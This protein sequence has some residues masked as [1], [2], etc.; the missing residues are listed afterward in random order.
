MTGDSP[1]APSPVVGGGAAQPAVPLPAA[2]FPPNLPGGDG[3]RPAVAGI[4]SPRLRNRRLVTSEVV[5]WEGQAFLINF[6][7]TSDGR[8]GELFA[9]GIGVKHGAALEMV[10]RQ[11]CVLASHL[12]EADPVG[13]V[14][15]IG[16]RLGRLAP[17]PLTPV[18]E[19]AIAIECEC[20]GIVADVQEWARAR[21]D[22]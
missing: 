19:R 22:A 1:E 6:G 14:E 11:A 17:G 12:I 5:E 2:S 8:I 7:W 3:S 4:S 18:I 20:G 15:R 21:G 16:R 9:D 10:M 13:G